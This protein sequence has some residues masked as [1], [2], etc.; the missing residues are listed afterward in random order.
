M[1]VCHVEFCIRKFINNR[2]VFHCISVSFFWIAFDKIFNWRSNAGRVCHRASE[3]DRRDFSVYS[4]ALLK[5]TCTHIQSQPD[6]QRVWHFGKFKHWFT[7]D[8]LPVRDTNINNSELDNV[9]IDASA[10]CAAVI[11][12][13]SML[14]I[15]SIRFSPFCTSICQTIAASQ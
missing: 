1:L 4:L 5:D 9:H 3:D 13:Y 6:R 11:L 14:F 8:W 15:F 12:K 10:L 2:K 7:I